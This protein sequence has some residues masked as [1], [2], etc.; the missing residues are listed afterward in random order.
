[1][2]LA[3]TF[4]NKIEHC[5]EEGIDREQRLLA[6]EGFW[7]T[8]KEKRVQTM[9]L[10]QNYKDVLPSLLN[11]AEKPRMTLEIQQELSDGMALEETMAGLFINS[12]NEDLQKEQE[13]KTA[14]LQEDFAKQLEEQQ[15]KFDAAKHEKR[16]KLIRKEQEDL[17]MMEKKQQLT[18][19]QLEQYRLNQ[20]VK[21]AEIAARLREEEELEACEREREAQKV[22]TASGSGGKGVAPEGSSFVDPKGSTSTSN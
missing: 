3:T 16:Q 20:R 13:G 14:K 15:A 19:Q 2:I 10:G 9:R 22:T 5:K 21:Q 1:M 17:K 4:W 12:E 6:N 7:K 18:N 11:M 8:M